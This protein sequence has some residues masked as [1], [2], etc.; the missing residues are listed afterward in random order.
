M[1]QGFQPAISSLLDT[2]LYKFTMWQVMLH[3]NPRATGVTG[4]CAATRRTTRWRN[5]QARCANN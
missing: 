5:W 2:D 1:T 3:Q 4:P